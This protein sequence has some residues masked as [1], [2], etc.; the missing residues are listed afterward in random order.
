MSSAEHSR[1]LFRALLPLGTLVVALFSILLVASCSSEA[2]RTV[3]SDTARRSIPVG[4]TVP[5]TALPQQPVTSRWPPGVESVVLSSETGLYVVD[6]RGVRWARENEATEQPSTTVTMR[7][8]PIVSGLDG[9][10]VSGN[11]QFLAYVEDGMEIVVRSIA[12]G[13]IVQRA[14]VQSNGH[15][16]LKSISPDGILA[17]LVT[18]DPQEEAAKPGDEVPWTVTVVDLSSGAATIEDTLADFVRGRMEAGGGC[19][20]VTLSRLPEYKLLV[21]VSGDPYETYLYDPVADRLMLIPELGYVW[22][23][24]PEGLVLGARA[25]EPGQAAI[26]NGRDGSSEM[27]T[28][29]SEWPCVGRGSLNADG[30][31]FVLWVSKSDELEAKHGWQVFRRTGSQWRPAGPVAEVDWVHQPP[32]LLS[33]DG[34]RAWTVVYQSTAD[35]ETVLLSHDF[36]TGAWEEWFRS[37]DMQVDWDPFSFVDIALGD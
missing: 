1:N 5:V 34:S 35:N 9:M 36:T 24:T 29:D 31:A 15:T 22:S 13:S 30:T 8:R 27:V 23:S 10:A 28:A 20:L 37:E 6:A 4:S 18:V 12:D 17:A 25:A 19:G 16:S 11:H 3:S 33:G 21:G 14:A 32:T 7:G 2:P 26:W